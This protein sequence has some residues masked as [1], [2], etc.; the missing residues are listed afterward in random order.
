[1]QHPS[2]QPLSVIAHRA[3]ADLMEEQIAAIELR[4]V[5]ASTTFDDLRAIIEVQAVCIVMEG[6]ASNQATA[7]ALLGSAEEAAAA[8]DLLDGSPWGAATLSVKL[9][10]DVQ[11]WLVSNGPEVRRPVPSCW[12]RLPAATATCPCAVAWCTAQPS[13]AP[14]M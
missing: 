8:C 9:V 2:L 13:G 14:P 6:S 11:E 3:T 12:R 4:G 5:P 1:M 7:L 10:P